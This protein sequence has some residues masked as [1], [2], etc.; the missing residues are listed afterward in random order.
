MYHVPQNYEICYWNYKYTI[1][2]ALHV[3][4][5]DIFYEPNSLDHGI[6][7]CGIQCPSTDQK[8][9]DSD[10]P[11]TTRG[12]ADQLRSPENFWTRKSIIRQLGL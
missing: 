3:S 11:E 10:I 8:A 7:V 12:K 9:M 5:Q 1:K 4:S 2:L 6:L